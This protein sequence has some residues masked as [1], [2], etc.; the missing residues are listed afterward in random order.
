[1]VA[2]P[3]VLRQVVYAAI[4]IVSFAAATLADSSVTAISPEQLAGLRDR[5]VVVV[6]VRRAEE[7]RA[8]GIV[9]GSRL[10]TAFDGEGRANPAFTDAVAAVVEPGRPVA[11]ICRTGNRSAAAGR[12]LAETGRYARIYNVDGGIRG[13]LDE[14]RP[15]TPCPTC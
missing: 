12:T 15:V 2:I 6:D 7:W 11:L 4:A 9:D 13:W 5:G 3:E 10:I 1:M 8:T 14:G